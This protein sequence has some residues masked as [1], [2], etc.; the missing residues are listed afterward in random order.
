M[1]GRWW[2]NVSPGPRMVQSLITHH[3][4]VQKLSG[5]FQINV[6]NLNKISHHALHRSRNVLV[7]L[8]SS[9]VELFLPLDVLAGDRVQLHC[10]QAE[11]E[12][13]QGWRQA[14][15]HRWHLTER[16]VLCSSETRSRTWNVQWQTDQQKRI[17]PGAS[18]L[19]SDIN[20]LYNRLPGHGECVS[21]CQGARGAEFTTPQCSI[22]QGEGGSFLAGLPKCEA[23]S[24]DRERD[25]V[26]RHLHHA[27]NKVWRLSRHVS[28]RLRNVWRLHGVSCITCDPP[29]HRRGKYRNI[30]LEGGRTLWGHAKEVSAQC[31]HVHLSLTFTVDQLI[32]RRPLTFQVRIRH[33]GS[34]GFF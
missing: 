12:Q 21:A 14:D 13:G 24:R 30:E 7:E 3:K 32:R 28:T 18:W 31:Q 27:K 10:S 15:R 5:P 33:T 23:E 4:P 25:R 2:R 34:E 17:H 26:V 6:G 16:S 19:F 22:K 9:V 29:S 8:L 11:R 1:K 20:K